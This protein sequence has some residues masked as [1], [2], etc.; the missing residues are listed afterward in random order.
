METRNERST[1]RACA[2]VLGALDFHEK[3]SQAVRRKVF[4]PRDVRNSVRMAMERRRT[5]DEYVQ[6]ELPGLLF[7]ET[8]ET[9]R[10]KP[11]RSFQQ[12]FQKNTGQMPVLFSSLSSSESEKTVTFRVIENFQLDYFGQ[13]FHLRSLI[14]NF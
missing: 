4:A 7:T 3:R 11:V 10:E 8:S 14:K 6:R 9:R 13:A 5:L 12:K 1:W 2:P